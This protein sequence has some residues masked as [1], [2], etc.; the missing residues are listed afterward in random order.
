MP[1]DSFVFSVP[2]ATCLP[3]LAGA[4]PVL[5]RKALRGRACGSLLIM[6][7]VLPPQLRQV[8]AS[9]RI[10]TLVR[11]DDKLYL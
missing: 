1:L 7:R 5:M 11:G 4:V 2:F 8:L 6:G 9:A 10:L 3:W